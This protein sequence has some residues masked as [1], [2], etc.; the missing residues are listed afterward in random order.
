MYQVAIAFL[1][2]L[3]AG[4]GTGLGGLLAVIRRPG[5]RLY[6]FLMG[7][8]SGVMITLSFLQ[9]VSEAWQMQGYITA[10][11]G[12][13]LGAIF[14]LNLDATIPHIHFGEEEIPHQDEHSVIEMNSFQRHGSLVTTTPPP[15]VLLSA[16]FLVSCCQVFSMSSDKE[17][18]T[19]IN[20]TECTR[21]FICRINQSRTEGTNMDCIFSLIRGNCQ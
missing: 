11:I 9:L 4:M 13:G 19:R 2:S 20:Y 1:L 7:F 6:G 10:T 15:L 8:T 17:K 12:F 18:M 5:P 16:R 21:I 3:M 14:M